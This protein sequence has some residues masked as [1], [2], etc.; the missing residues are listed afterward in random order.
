[1]SSKL[2]LIHDLI[3]ICKVLIILFDL[4]L[5]PLLLNLELKPGGIWPYL[6]EFVEELRAPLAEFGLLPLALF[7]QYLFKDGLSVIRIGIVVGHVDFLD[8]DFFETALEAFECILE[9]LLSCSPYLRCLWPSA[10]E[11][12]LWL[13]S[14]ATLKTKWNLGVVTVV[15]RADDWGGALATFVFFLE[16]P[17]VSVI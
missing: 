10:A 15:E 3:G 13:M 14:I 5:F 6:I 7:L 11:W 1:M 9:A 17:I 8:L 12:V 2:G 4:L 16:L